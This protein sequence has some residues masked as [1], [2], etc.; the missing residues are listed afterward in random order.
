MKNFVGLVVI[1]SVLVFAYLIIPNEEGKS[2]INMG[3]AKVIHG[4]IGGEKKHFLENPKVLNIL[5]SRYEILVDFQKSG[6]L[7]MVRSA[8]L[9]GKD[10]LWPSNQ[11]AVEFFQERGLKTYGQEIIFNS[12]IVIYTWKEVSEA[13]EKKGMI[14]TFNGVS[15]LK[16]MDTL[17]QMMLEGENWSSLGLEQLYGKIKLFS[18]DPLFSNSGNMF[19]ALLANLLNGGEVLGLNHFEKVMPKL[20]QFY[21][22]MG[23][24]ERSSSDIFEN[25]LKMGIGARPMIAGYENQMVEFALQ[26]EHL[27]TVIQEKIVV[28]YPVPTIW[29][30]H[31]M[32]ALN[33]NGKLLLEALKDK[34]IQNIAWTEHG[35]RSG[36]MAVE[37]DPKAL[38]LLGVPA[39][40]TAVTQ[41]PGMAVIDRFMK[42]L[43]E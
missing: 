4:Y 18:T 12:P 2:I 1:L 37:N 25:F 22:R 3:K 13:L 26:N 32:I 20:K 41:M 10:F 31:P 39:R 8:P 35:F 11:V 15:F 9:N 16:D 36:V 7:E 19:Y 24:M 40:V 17:I 21:A 27:R 5:R 42:E 28:L 38:N 30:S 23:F 29:S 14:Q 6:S 43:K 34:E 33:E